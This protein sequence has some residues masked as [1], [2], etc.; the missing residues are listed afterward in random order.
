MTLSLW[1][2]SVEKEMISLG[3]LSPT[4]K[5]SHNATLFSVSLVRICRLSL[6]TLYWRI[7]APPVKIKLNKKM[8]STIYM[9]Q[10]MSKYPYLK[11]LQ[12]H[13]HRP[14]KLFCHYHRPFYKENVILQI[15]CEHDILQ[16]YPRDLFKTFILIWLT[17]TKNDWKKNAKGNSCSRCKS[18][19]REPLLK[20]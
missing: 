3:V 10:K 9:P 2:W 5:T 16:N 7:L 8:I 17:K 4:V 18:S 1:L 19:A 12:Y 13:R 15:I 11:L 14:S 6:R 20:V